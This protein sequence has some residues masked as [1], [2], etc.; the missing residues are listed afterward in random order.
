[1]RRAINVLVVLVLTLPATLAFPGPG[2]PAPPLRLTQLLQAPPS[3]QADWNALHGKVVVLEFWATWCE[4]CVAELPQFNKLVASLEPK[5]FQFISVDDEDPEIIGSFLK[6]R[7]IAG[8]IGIDTTGD[9]LKRFRVRS[10]PTTII[11][12]G[13][14]RIV[15]RTHP[16]KLTA[17]DLVAVARGTKVKFAHV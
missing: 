9:V 15:A 13:Q 12:D 10:R 8:W 14:G 16:E 11:I 4:V 17:A 3:A 2:T 6:K 5:K 1:M 7:K